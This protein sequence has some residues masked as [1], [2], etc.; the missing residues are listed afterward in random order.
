MTMLERKVGELNKELQLV[1]LIYISTN[2]L[3]QQYYKK[4]LEALLPYLTYSSKN[5][6]KSSLTS[7]LEIK[8]ILG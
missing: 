8:L 3:L 6:L 2:F 1:L 5:L 4:E 7:C